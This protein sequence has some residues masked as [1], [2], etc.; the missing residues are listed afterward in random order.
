MTH[1]DLEGLM[2]ER[3]DGVEPSVDPAE[4]EDGYG[5]VSGNAWGDAGIV[6]HRGVLADGEHV[7]AEELQA[8]VEAELGYTYAEVSAVYKV[9]GRLTATQRE[10]RTYVDARL[11]A[12]SLSGAN[13]TLVAEAIGIA[14]ATLNRAL[15][16]AR[17]LYIEPVPYTP[18][19]MKTR[20]CFTCDSMEARPRKHRF[21]KEFID[22]KF[23]GERVTI[24]LCDPCYSKGFQTRPGNDAYWASRSQGKP[25][26]A[27]D[28][29]RSV[30]RMRELLRTG[31]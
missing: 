5:I 1:E 4:L 27:E 2:Q 12:L 24:D 23:R 11:L 19:V 16:R 30:V 22:A 13:I 3:P 18:V 9:G 26:T 10:F 7:D 21:N 25:V 31:V 29:E 28:A 15:D 14:R 17:E 20:S 6:A 8:A